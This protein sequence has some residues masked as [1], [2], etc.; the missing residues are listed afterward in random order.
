VKPSHAGLAAGAAIAWGCSFVVIRLGLDDLPPL[1]F[2]SLRFAL[3]ALPAVLFVGRPDV[4]WRSTVLVGVTLG[5]A[6]Y[7]L[8]FAG[9]DLGMPAGAASVVLQAQVPLT[10]LAGC[11]LLG[12]RISASVVLAVGVSTAGLAVIAVA[13]GGAGLLPF[14]LVIGAAVA[15]ATSNI[16]IRIAQPRR[17]VALIVWASL[18][19][20]L[21][22]FGLSLL[23]D[24]SAEVGAA[25][26]GLDA[27]SV[28]AVLYLAL[29]ATLWAFSVW[30]A[31]LRT[32]PAR[33]VAPFALLIPVAG[34]A[35]TWIV[36]GEQPPGLELL[37]SA[38]V[39]AGLVI[40]IRQSGAPAEV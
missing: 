34:I 19:A 21:P 6:Q 37:G 30:S 2:A 26:R 33:V 24:G 13:R 27:G 9:I 32:Y 12:E 14:M 35:S 18:V 36:L 1:L 5:V 28:A 23:F 31:L 4:G 20:P 40:V 22:L 39:L 11:L 38:L 7:G 16:V 10:V 17:P 29:V 15:W 8:L 25:L 3:V